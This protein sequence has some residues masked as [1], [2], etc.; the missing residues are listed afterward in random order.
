LSGDRAQRIAQVDYDFAAAPKQAVGACNLCGSAVFTVIAHSDRYGYAAETHACSR[1]GLTFMNPQMTQD[2]IGQFYSDVY[3]PLVSAFHGRVIDARSVEDEQ[4]G[5]AEALVDLLEPFVAGTEGGTL[6]DMG[7]STG[8]IA[9]AFARRLGLDATV[10]DPSPDEL[11]RARER[12]LTTV[13]GTTETFDAA[14]ASYDLV[15]LCQTIDHVLDV[16]GAL[17]TLRAALAEG[18]IFFVDIVDFRAAYL[19]N[20]SVE[21]ATKIDHPYYLTE[22]TFEAFLRRAGFDVLRKD[23]AADHLHVGYV[24]RGGEPEPDALPPAGSVERLFGEIR[25]TQNAPR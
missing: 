25:R 17:R 6:L 21:A 13:E 16:A 15:L 8:V 23:Y 14:G 24:C 5:Y 2:A 22:A 11:E 10:C 20:A 9:E 4:Q 18:G 7:G 19:R 1:C 3:R 12:G